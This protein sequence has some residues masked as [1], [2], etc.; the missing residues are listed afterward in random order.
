MK[1][2]FKGRLTKR[3]FLHAFEVAREPLVIANLPVPAKALSTPLIIS[4][5]GLVIASAAS[6]IIIGFRI[7][8]GDAGKLGEIVWMISCGVSLGVPLLAFQAADAFYR[9]WKSRKLLREPL[10]GA[11]AYDGI[12]LQRPSGRQH[13]CWEDFCIYRWDDTLVVLFYGDCQW[14]PFPKRYFESETDWEAFRIIVARELDL[15]EP[16]EQT[17]LS[18]EMVL[19]AVLVAALTGLL[20]LGIEVARAV[21]PALAPSSHDLWQRVALIEPVVLLGSVTTAIGAILTLL[22]A[23][24][25]A[26]LASLWPTLVHSRFIGSPK[27][28]KL[29]ARFQELHR[30]ADQFSSAGFVALGVKVERPLWGV[31]SREM[32][33]MSKQAEAYGDVSTVWFGMPKETVHLYTPF[34]DGGIIF[35]T[36]WAFVKPSRGAHDSVSVI[37]SSSLDHLLKVH[38]QRI[39][40]FKDQGRTP[41][42]GPTAEHRIA[43]THQYYASAAGRRSMRRHAI[44][45]AAQTGLFVVLTVAIVAAGLAMTELRPWYDLIP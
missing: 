14:M 38:T 20:L 29:M 31:G 7:A 2:Q 30:W 40:A 3:D 13:L 21:V 39:Q 33:F 44:R 43:A 24:I 35:T 17:V 6:L 12:E 36:T 15:P 45:A 10:R 19:V 42:I 41:V 8:A 34:T 32:A 22:F 11:V 9:Q 37:K 26:L 25:P 23:A 27:S 1:I 28:D 4:A 16:T 5:A 18:R